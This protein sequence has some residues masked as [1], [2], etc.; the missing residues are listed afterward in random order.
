MIALVWMHD[1]HPKEQHLTTYLVVTGVLTDYPNVKSC[2]VEDDICW[3]HVRRQ[4]GSHWWQGGSALGKC[5]VPDSR[6]GAH[7]GCLDDV[8]EH[9]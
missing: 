7:A 8:L 2:T 1:A 5:F 4:I 6:F 3:E 9:N